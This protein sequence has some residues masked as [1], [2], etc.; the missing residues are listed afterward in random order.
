MGA[1]LAQQIPALIKGCLKI[2]KPLGAV[3]DLTW[4]LLHFATQLMLSID[5]LA[6]AR[7]DV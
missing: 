1:S 3:T 6:D 5:H 7:E 2:M 4:V